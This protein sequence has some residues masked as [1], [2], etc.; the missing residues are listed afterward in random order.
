MK[1]S[2]EGIIMKHYQVYKYKQH[3]EAKQLFLGH[4]MK[5]TCTAFQELL[6]P[7][8]WCNWLTESVQ[9]NKE[10]WDRGTWFTP[11]PIDIITGTH[12]IPMGHN[13]T[14]TRM[15]LRMY[16]DSPTSNTI[17]IE[18]YGA[19]NVPYE[20]QQNLPIIYNK[21]ILKPCGG[22]VCLFA[23]S[24][25]MDNV[26]D[27]KDMGASIAKVIEVCTFGLSVV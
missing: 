7:I 16:R 6:H 20:Q 2:Q 17:H 10:S 18:V 5:K 22:R 11:W 1:T 21:S 19:F 23:D 26:D 12:P 4:Q 9:L 8:S 15:C 25:D 27:F 14:L 3:A 24:I 13:V